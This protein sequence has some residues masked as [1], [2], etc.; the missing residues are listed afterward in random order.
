MLNPLSGETRDP[1]ISSKSLEFL[2]NQEDED[3]INLIVARQGSLFIDTNYEDDDYFSDDYTQVYKI[4]EFEQ[5]LDSR[6]DSIVQLR[7]ANHESGYSGMSGGI[8][9]AF[10][11][12]S[13][14]NPSIASA[15]GM[16]QY[17]PKI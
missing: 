1:Q 9:T 4:P 15:G 7:S 12:S 3:D 2:E 17:V 8:A 13:F 14:R 6:G 10:N 16:M 5:Q 11:P